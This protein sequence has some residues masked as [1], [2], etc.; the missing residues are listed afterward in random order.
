MRPVSSHS[1]PSG[2]AAQER[3]QRRLPRVAAV[4]RE[5]ERVTP[6]ELFFDLVFV[7]A[8]TQCTTLMAGEPTWRG[9]LEGLLVL[10]VLWW[11]WVGYA[12]LTSAVDPEEGLVR[13]AMF[14]AMAAFVIAALCVPKVFGRDALARAEPGRQQNRIARDAYS[15]LHF[16]MVAGVALIAVGLKLTLPHT[17]A[18]LATVPAVALLG[19]AAAFLV[20][21]FAFRLR[22]MHT[23]GIRRLVFAAAILALAPLAPSISALALLGAESALLVAMILYE[24]LR[25]A[26]VR[27]RVRH[28]VPE[29]GGA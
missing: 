26:D 1:P 7:L 8:L 18:S 22:V 11:S 13:L 25:Y 5:G 16:P 28:R 3:R 21:Q 20:A 17:G 14:A 15:Y 24:A 23:L 19:G 9:L 27:G 12:W 10:G 4:M 29:A 6:L 2:E